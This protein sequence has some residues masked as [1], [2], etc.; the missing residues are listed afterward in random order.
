MGLSSHNVNARFGQTWKIVYFRYFP[1]LLLN[2]YDICL[3]F[4]S[5]R[6]SVVILCLNCLFLCVSEKTKFDSAISRLQ[7]W[8][9][10]QCVILIV[11]FRRSSQWK[12]KSVPFFCFVFFLFHLFE[13][14]DDRLE[15]QIME[16]WC[17]NISMSILKLVVSLLFLLNVNGKDAIRLMWRL[18]WWFRNK[19]CN[20]Y[21]PSVA[22]VL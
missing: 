3:F 1:P 5:A 14:W 22:A 2:D 20:I 8:V 17:C 18:C 15:K 13:H 12:I 10:L 19:I 21:C 9:E 4:I 16:F 11:R 7:K 6:V